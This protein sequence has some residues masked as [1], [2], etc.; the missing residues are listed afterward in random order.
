MN[1]TTLCLGPIS[2]KPSEHLPESLDWLPEPKPPASAMVN[3][4]S[5]HEDETASAVHEQ[6]VSRDAYCESFSSQTSEPTMIETPPQDERLSDER[7][8]TISSN[9]AESVERAST[10]FAESSGSSPLVES[11]SQLKRRTI[12]NGKRLSSFR[13]K[14]FAL[15][16]R[17]QDDAHSLLCTTCAQRRKSAEST[18]SSTNMQVMQHLQRIRQ[19]SQLVDVLHIPRFQLLFLSVFPLIALLLL[20]LRPFTRLVPSCSWSSLYACGSSSSEQQTTTDTLPPQDTEH[21]GGE[22]STDE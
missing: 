20:V 4:T 22:S 1:L 14:V 3:G 8:T 10:R 2:S 16:V 13:V 19:S 7:F 11:E 18:S 15:A 17:E 12:P 6:G 21:T 5:D 9:S